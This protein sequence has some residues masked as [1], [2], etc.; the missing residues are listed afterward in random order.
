MQIKHRPLRSFDTR[1]VLLFTALTL[2]GGMVLN[3]HAQSGLHP[4]NSAQPA[5]KGSA[6]KAPAAATDAAASAEAFDRADTNRD[7][8]L[9]PQEATHIPAIAQRFKEL[10]ADGNGQLS[11]SEFQRGAGS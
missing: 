7:G 2:G 4:A 9:S 6:K 8:Q 3:A 5:E 1:S 11:R 10:D